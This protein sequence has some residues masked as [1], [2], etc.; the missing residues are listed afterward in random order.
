M[1]RTDEEWLNLENKI[2]GWGVPIIFF[3]FG[4]ITFLFSYGCTKK[5]IIQKEKEPEIIEK[6]ENV[7]KNKEVKIIEIP[8]KKIEPKKELK[9]KLEFKNVYFDFDKT[10]LSSESKK[11]LKQNAMILKYY[12]EKRIL[13]EGHT[14]EIGD[15]SYNLILGYNRA[16]IVCE[17]YDTLGV[18][19]SKILFRS[20]GEGAP[21]NT[22]HTPEA[23]KKNRR[24]VT[25]IYE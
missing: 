6:V 10:D 21:V 2:V 15:V 16:K 5:G 23:R 8:P 9:P 20:Y 14:D 1:F 13:I 17:Y 19:E 3:I 24:V 11:I 12:P 7:E 4:V 22:L 18:S 25:R